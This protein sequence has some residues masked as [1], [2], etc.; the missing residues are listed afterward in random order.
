M[1]SQKPKQIR[2]FEDE[3]PSSKKNWTE[4]GKPSLEDFRE[5]RVAVRDDLVNHILGELK[6]KDFCVISGPRD[7]GKTWLSHAVA[8]EL[9][10]QKENIKFV[11]LDED[12]DPYEIWSYVKGIQGCY[13]IVEN[14][15]R[16]MDL[17]ADLVNRVFAEPGNRK[18]IFT[19]CDT[20]AL[21]ILGDE[22]CWIRLKTGDDEAAKH[23]K[24][25][26]EKFVK[27]K[28]VRKKITVTD[29]EIDAAAEKWKDGDLHDVFVRLTEGWRF[30]KKMRL[31]EVEDES[32]F[33]SMFDVN[34]KWKLGLQKRLDVFLALSTM[35]QFESAQVWDVYLQRTDK[36]NALGE[37]EDEGL[38]ERRIWLGN[39]FFRIGAGKASWILRAIAWQ[40]DP[41]GWQKDPT[42]SKGSEYVCRE[43]IKTFKDYIRQKPPNWS[44]II[45]CVRASREA[46]LF[47]REIPYERKLPPVEPVMG[48]K[49]MPKPVS[50]F[51]HC[52]F[53]DE[54]IWT[55]IREMAETGYFFSLS[56]LP[57]LSKTLIAAYQG[58][59]EEDVVQSLL[60]KDAD[61]ILHELAS[62][63]LSAINDFLSFLWKRVGWVR[64]KEVV[65][66]ID[67]RD[68]KLARY[69][70]ST[71]QRKCD[72]CF[73]ISY[74]NMPMS[75]LIV[76]DMQ[77]QL[78]ET[79]ASNIRK[80]L[81]NLS[82]IQG[83]GVVTLEEFFDSF[84]TSDWEK[85]IRNSSTIVPVFHL[86]HFDFSKQKSSLRKTAVSLS[87]AFMKSNLT[88]LIT[89]KKA[90]LY[91]LAGIIKAAHE[92]NL[93]TKT[94]VESILSADA[95]IL[96]PLYLNEKKREMIWA[97]EKERL[98]A[99]KRE[100][101]VPKGAFLAA[102]NRIA[103]IAGEDAEKD[104]QINQK[105][106]SLVGTLAKFE[107][108]D[109]RD[110]FRDIKS[111]NYF[112]PNPAPKAPDACRSIMKKIGFDA[113]FGLI[114]SA[115]RDE[116]AEKQYAFW[117]LWNIY[118]FDESLAKRLSEKS[119][120]LFSENVNDS[121]L[122]EVLLPIIGLF[123][124][125]SVNTE[126]DFQKIDFET[127]SETLESYLEGKPPG[128]ATMIL[129]SLIA[130][131]QMAPREK[132]DTVKKKAMNDPDVKSCLYSN[133]DTQL[134]NV[135]SNLIRKY[136]F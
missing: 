10:Q 61:R 34:G 72:L 108:E 79:S 106:A 65:K 30:E 6:S 75:K 40:K 56:L 63:H 3:V 60:Q 5:R 119:L 59:K 83:V 115:L 47:I 74:A 81:R 135:F 8:F 118:R 124:H 78:K 94:L 109:L 20:K 130:L 117:L 7:S 100:Y 89:Q 128:Y 22:A 29:G 17:V 85:I 132:F 4:L 66:K 38:I 129:L 16:R 62:S 15:H 31:A 44:Y 13:F 48:L 11:E 68:S 77:K 18:F 36:E 86:L 28:E 104:P 105:I 27:I 25:I 73:L 82:G 121:K 125:L 120:P 64:F 103:I 112:F 51:L 90:D 9:N 24:G 19:G 113:W 133:R 71:V 131:N 52:I 41:I 45:Y 43:I 92:L 80:V 98:A 87:E 110:I 99:V 33:S 88:D 76:K 35:C 57:S 116:E 55:A 58:E 84:L 93:E 23:I 123:N 2:E 12:F 14:C 91:A 49:R 37:L 97:T 53:E 101:E 26:I 95:K 127:A 134:Q 1:S 39:F 102:L 96:K 122:A 42:G 126:H 46:P 54:E 32:V 69:K 70:E 21:S 107:A 111:V 136:K 114:Q 50:E 67:V